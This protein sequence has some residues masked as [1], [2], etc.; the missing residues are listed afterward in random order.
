VSTSAERTPG[1]LYVAERSMWT[2]SSVRFI[3]TDA[4]KSGVIAATNDRDAPVFA[5]AYDL[6]DA[7]KALLDLVESEGRDTGTGDA[8]SVLRDAIAKAEGR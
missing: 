5:A 3:R 8:F 7:A 1:T 6:L 4:D 2:V